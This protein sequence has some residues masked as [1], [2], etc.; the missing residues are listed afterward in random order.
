MV[1]LDDLRGLFQLMTLVKLLSL[2][3]DYANN[4]WFNYFLQITYPNYT[5]EEL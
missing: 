1:G 5:V 2:Y 3:L 4:A